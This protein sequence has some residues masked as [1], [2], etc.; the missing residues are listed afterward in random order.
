[1]KLLSLLFP[2]AMASP[3]APPATPTPAP[4]TASSDSNWNF[5]NGASQVQIQTTGNVTF[6]PDSD[7]LFDLHGN[8]TLRV[9]EK[10]GHDVRVLTAQGNEVIYKVNGTVRPYEAD[11]KAW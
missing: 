2:V 10:N 7:A 5:Q 11:A 3:P 9:Q 8:G 4:P 6:D 1:M